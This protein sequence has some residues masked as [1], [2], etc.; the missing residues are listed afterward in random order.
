MKAANEDHTKEMGGLLQENDEM[1]KAIE[2]L[3]SHKRTGDYRIRRL[4]ED[5]EAER[6]KKWELVRKIS[7]LESGED[8][9]VCL[10]SNEPLTLHEKIEL[11]KEGWSK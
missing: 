6:K 1:K 10:D 7:L 3:E 5:L 2:D 11:I 8:F 9:K 4:E